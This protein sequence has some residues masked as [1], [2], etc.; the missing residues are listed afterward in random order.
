VGHIE[1]N[2]PPEGGAFGSS[3][4][5]PPRNQRTVEWLVR[6][7]GEG[8]SAS[9]TASAQRAGTASKKVPLPA[10]R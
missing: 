8:P 4:Q 10:S 5:D 3:R 9:I 1:G 7:K 2:A 6:L